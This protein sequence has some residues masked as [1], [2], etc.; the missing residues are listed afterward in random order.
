MH[1]RVVCVCGGPP[2]RRPSR[3]A[4]GWRTSYSSTTKRTRKSPI[5]TKYTGSSARHVVAVGDLPTS[6]V[7]AP[8]L[9]LQEACSAANATRTR[10]N[11][12]PSNR[13]QQASQ[14]ACIHLALTAPFATDLGSRHRS[15]RN[16]LRPAYDTVQCSSS[17]RSRALPRSSPRAGA[18]GAC[19]GCLRAQ[20]QPARLPL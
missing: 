17:C 5:A 4:Q 6:S 20:R 1:V 11:P 14:G 9:V 15:Q 12:H 16:N 8:K 13:L 2:C 3:D 10:V 7:G 19:R 18:V